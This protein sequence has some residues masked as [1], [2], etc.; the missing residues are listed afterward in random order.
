MICAVVFNSCLYVQTLTQPRLLV[1]REDSFVAPCSDI[2]GDVDVVAV[3]KDQE[4]VGR[5]TQGQTDDSDSVVV[6][7][8]AISNKFIEYI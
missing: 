1:R 8:L 4:A 7:C 6:C 2:S 3:F 5:P